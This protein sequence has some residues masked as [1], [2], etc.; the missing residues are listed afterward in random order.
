MGGAE[1]VAEEVAVIFLFGAMSVEMLCRLMLFCLAGGM[2]TRA[3]ISKLS[4]SDRMME[5]GAGRL[6]M[7]IVML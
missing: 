2:S 5:R 3:F 7:C 1:A 6:V 4:I